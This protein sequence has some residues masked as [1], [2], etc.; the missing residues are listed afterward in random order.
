[1]ETSYHVPGPRQLFVPVRL[2]LSLFGKCRAAL[3]ER[4]ERQRIRAMLLDLSDRELRD[5]GISRNEIE[6]LALNRDIDSRHPV[7]RTKV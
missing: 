1:M 2:G 5:V 6:Y 3:I 7:R 4:R